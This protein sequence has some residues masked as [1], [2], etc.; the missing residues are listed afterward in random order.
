MFIMVEVFK[1]TVSEIT[2]CEELIR[3]IENAFNNYKVNF[4]L[5]D[6]DNILRV[7]CINGLVE[8][9]NLIRF[10]NGLGFNAQVLPD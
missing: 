5:D 3:E 10:L 7:E 2:Q 8:S 1:T 9:T 6:C 4:D